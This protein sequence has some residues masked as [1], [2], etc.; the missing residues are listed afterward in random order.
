MSN[1][2]TNPYLV[3]LNHPE[4]RAPYPYRPQVWKEAWDEL[5][6][7]YRQACR[8]LKVELSVEVFETWLDAEKKMHYLR[9]WMSMVGFSVS[10]K[11]LPLHEAIEKEVAKKE[12]QM[13]DHR[14]EYR[15][16][17]TQLARRR[18][19]GDDVRARIRKVR[20][21]L[22]RYQQDILDKTQP[23]LEKQQ[24]KFLK[25]HPGLSLPSKKDLN[26]LKNSEINLS[27]QS[28]RDKGL[29][30]VVVERSGTVI[31]SAIQTCVHRE[32]REAIWKMRQE[33]YLCTDKASSRLFSARQEMAKKY[34]FDSYA[35]HELASRMH[36]N[37]KSLSKVLEKS[38][39][40]GADLYDQLLQFLENF[41]KK[42]AMID[43]IEEWD[44]GFLMNSFSAQKV[45]EFP[46]CEFP[47]IE[48]LIKAVPELIGIV[49]WDVKKFHIQGKGPQTMLHWEVI[50]NEESHH[51]WIAPFQ[52][53]DVKDLSV[54]GDAD[55]FRMGPDNTLHSI[56]HLYC[57]Y[58]N[59]GFNLMALKTLAHEVGHVL[60][61]LSMPSSAGTV[62]G[63]L[64]LREVPSVLL[65]HYPLDP[66]VL[67]AWSTNS[68]RSLAFWKKQASYDDLSAMLMVF[69]QNF[70]GWLDLFVNIE[71]PVSLKKFVREIPE[72]FGFRTPHK[73]STAWMAYA[74][75]LDHGATDY[76]YHL[77]Y[78]V[79][80]R[81]HPSLG[82]TPKAQ[83]I[84]KE[85]KRLEEKVLSRS[86][87]SP[88]AVRTSWK[89]LTGETILQSLKKG[90][91][92]QM[93]AWKKKLNAM[94]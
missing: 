44:V 23:A 49:G 60:H 56:I 46:E 5:Y 22:I 19:L 75:W 30:G 57:N 16:L 13:D 71:P 54:Q 55:F 34:G 33:S 40:K 45:G 32:V 6:R 31:D 74:M 66:Q 1:A 4:K 68:N 18:S 11:D 20:D 39:I 27:R 41:G 50:R 9:M 76:I 94:N 84:A 28:A 93:N 43:E 14:P 87:L 52:V 59:P 79:N 86:H 62:G 25:S 26:G 2:T 64:D 36:T 82:A 69:M 35:E 15:N 29:N 47:W 67:K 7:T 63:P 48:T 80:H 58:E 78:A 73:D 83:R 65:E 85:F 53:S 88:S 38:M 12:K 3:W 89:E 17:L 90:S 81:L 77:S 24:A 72:Q 21:T 37:P 42:N 92:T 61:W 91:K 10:N 70:S 51:L 8:T